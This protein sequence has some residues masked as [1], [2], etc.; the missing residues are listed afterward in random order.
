MILFETGCLDVAKWFCSIFNV[1]HSMLKFNYHD[2]NTENNVKIQLI[3]RNVHKIKKIHEIW[4][5]HTYLG[6]FIHQ[7]VN[8]LRPS[9]I[10]FQHS[11]LD[12]VV[13]LEIEFRFSI[14]TNYSLSNFTHH[15]MHTIHKNAQDRFTLL[16]KPI[17]WNVFW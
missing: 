13:P 14:F 3:I 7:I 8:E 5:F 2:E 4:Q 10:M 1:M 17:Q 15:M 16:L 12:I 11:K 9:W 6:Y